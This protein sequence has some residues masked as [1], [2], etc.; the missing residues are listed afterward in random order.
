M[1]MK[2][3]VEK[4]LPIYLLGLPS[5]RYFGNNVGRLHKD[6]VCMK[7]YQAAVGRLFKISMR[8]PE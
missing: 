1:G 8:D 2:A 3:S 6:P 7:K 5:L 4:H